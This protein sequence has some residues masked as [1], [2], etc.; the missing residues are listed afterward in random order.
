MP[1]RRRTFTPER[2]PRVPGHRQTASPRRAPS[3]KRAERKPTPNRQTEH[4]TCQRKPRTNHNR[5]HQPTT[6]GPPHPQGGAPNPCGWPTA[7]HASARP[8][9]GH[10]LR[11]LGGQL[12]PVATLGAGEQGD[13]Q[14]LLQPVYLGEQRARVDPEFGG[15]DRQVREI[16][17]R[18]ESF[19][20]FPPP[21]PRSAGLISAG[22]AA[23]ACS[24]ARVAL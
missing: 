7:T 19:E 1:A 14:I 16:G 3:W 2:H 18:R 8:D 23:A 13:V 10:H 11:A 22:A 24:A 17:C 9:R 12:H 4:H 5:T 20:A 6:S 15:R 21:I